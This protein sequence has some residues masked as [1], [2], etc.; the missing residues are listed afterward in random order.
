MGRSGEGWKVFS[1]RK[2]SS[3]LPFIVLQS[4]ELSCR[5]AACRPQLTAAQG[6]G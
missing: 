3:R 1:T 2:L 5:Y 6:R 4:K